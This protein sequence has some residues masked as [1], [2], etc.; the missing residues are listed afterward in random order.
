MHYK[1]LKPLLA[2]FMVAAL[3]LCGCGDITVEPTEFQW[4]E[5]G[6]G[7]TLDSAVATHYVTME[8][9]NYGTIKAELYGY[10]AP[11]S[12]KNFVTLAESGFYNGLT[13]HRII[14]G[15]MMQGGAPNDNSPEVAP[16][17]GEFASNGLVNN[18][19]HRRG[20]LSMARASQMDSATSQFFIMH[21]PAPHLD[22]DYAAFGLVTEGMD[23]VDRICTEAQPYNNNGGIAAADQPVIKSITVELAK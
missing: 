7:S 18:L 15:F 1:F 16:I 12:V 23:V 11:I 6:D 2:I 14:E 13:F 17:K 9:E 4:P 3:F 21:Q 22:G 10:A 8:I 19:I 5:A 20:V